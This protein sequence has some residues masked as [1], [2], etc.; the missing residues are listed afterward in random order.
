MCV[1]GCKWCSRVWDHISASCKYDVLFVR[2]LV[3][4]WGYIVV[5][6]APMVTFV[7]DSNMCV[8]YRGVPLPINARPAS[9][10]QQQQPL[11]PSSS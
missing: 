3:R 1:L 2:F 7:C 5:V 9:R 10:E 11:P 4:A 6:A 8:V